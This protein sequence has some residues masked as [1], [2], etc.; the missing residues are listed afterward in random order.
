ME[1]GME[2]GM[3]LCAT[4]LAGDCL[5]IPEGW[6]HQVDSAKGTLA[7]NIWFDGVRAQMLPQ[8]RSAP[9]LS[10]P[11]RGDGAGGDDAGFRSN[12]GGVGD[13]LKD[14]TF[15]HGVETFYLRALLE[16]MVDR[17]VRSRFLEVRERIERS[18]ERSRASHRDDGASSSSPSSSGSGSGSGWLHSAET[19]FV[20]SVM[21]GRFCDCADML[22]G[23]S[24]REIRTCLPHIVSA[25]P[26]AW[27]TFLFRMG[28]RSAALMLRC[29]DE[30]E[31]GAQEGGSK[32]SEA[33]G[34]S[35]KEEGGSVVERLFDVFHEIEKVRPFA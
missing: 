16:G 14:P 29:W 31:E 15:D 30:L 7:V 5:F 3:E 22:V 27:Q 9:P 18:K 24:P 11:A 32:A 20:A 8:Q 17:E 34:T 33:S 13:P 1:H 28:P 35:S 2:H 6:W 25:H 23:L 21:A 26:C 10:S 4:L 12:A 19:S